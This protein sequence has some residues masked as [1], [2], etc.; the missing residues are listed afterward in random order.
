VICSLFVFFSFLYNL[1]FRLVSVIFVIKTTFLFYNRRVWDT[2]IRDSAGMAMTWLKKLEKAHP[3]LAEIA[4]V[5]MAEKSAMDIGLSVG[6]GAPAGFYEMASDKESESEIAQ[7]RKR[8]K[9]S[10]DIS[11]KN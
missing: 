5:R 10:V 11:D 3:D 7:E 2:T 8:Q 6:T 1:V 4:R 9:T